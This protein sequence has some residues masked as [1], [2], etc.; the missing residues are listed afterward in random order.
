M[1]SLTIEDGEKRI[2]AAV[3]SQKLA[4]NSEHI[5]LDE[6]VVVSGK[7]NKDFR[8]QWQ[9]VV[10]RIDP[11]DKIQI[12]YA[13]Y[14][15]IKLTEENKNEYSILCDLLKKYQGKCPVIIE[16]QS[17]NSSGKIPLSK[18]FDV[19]LNREFLDSIEKRFGHGKYKIQ[20]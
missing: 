5:L 8:E 14:L 10:D 19:S 15:N 4:E 9:I 3:F 6:V 7:I 16:Y 1:A 20:Y 11:V 17:T 12:K 13:K 2:N 18:G